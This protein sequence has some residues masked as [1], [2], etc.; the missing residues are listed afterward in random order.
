MRSL[1]PS[2]SESNSVST[3][4]VS[5]IHCVLSSNA[6]TICACPDSKTGF[7]GAGAWR[8][9]G[10]TEKAVRSAAARAVAPGGELSVFIGSARHP[11]SCDCV[12]QFEPLDD[13]HAANHP[14]E[15]SEVPFIMWLRCHAERIA[16]PAGVESGGGPTQVAA[17][18]P[19]A[20]D[21]VAQDKSA[22][23]PRCWATK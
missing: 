7:A 23:I 19:A 1:R 22:L 11:R 16:R 6:G 8:A 4:K 2:L 12:H 9:D 20:A 10:K 17:D 18:Q 5:R 15:R 21:L 14:S 13:V 3:N